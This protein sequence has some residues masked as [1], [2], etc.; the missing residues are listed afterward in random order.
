MKILQFTSMQDPQATAR[1]VRATRRTAATV[2]LDLE[3]SLWDVLDETRTPALKAAGR[4]D[5]VTLAQ[6]HHALFA[7]Q[8]IGVRVNRLAGPYAALDF[9]ALGRA[10]KYVEFECVIPTKV[11]SAAAIRENIAGLRA[12]GVA[13]RGL[14]PI[15][16]TRRG[17]ANLDEILEAARGAGVE[18]LVYGLYD[19]S[20]D[21]GW[22][23]FP[24]PSEPLY[25]EMVEPL[26]PRW[27]A[28]G[29]GFVQPPYFQTHDGAGM[30]AI[31]ERLARACT[32]EFGL[33]TVGLRQTEVVLRLSGKTPSDD[34]D[35][36][37]SR[38]ADIIESADLAP[39]DYARYVVETFLAERRHSAGVAL[40]PK[41]GEFISPH[42][43]LAAR[44]YLRRTGDG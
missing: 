11:E 20:L 31:L 42:V 33:L 6:A 5:L 10:S 43:F 44:D 15:V 39:G 27:E 2:V 12:A 29:L 41:S 7:E 37:A 17:L 35:G 21:S 3:D 8:R 24:R 25:W 36:G 4:D 9:E 13:Y 22:W 38:G 28:A 1:L 23:P 34:D 40:D 19:L 18:W 32:R 16:E 30:A 26:I 14:V